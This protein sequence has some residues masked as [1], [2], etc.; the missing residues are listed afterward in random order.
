MPSL[1]MLNTK[2]IIDQQGRPNLN[3]DALGSAWFVKGIQFA[4]DPTAEMNALTNLNVKDSA[5]MNIANQKNIAGINGYDSSASIKLIS[6]S[7]DV[8]QYQANTK[9]TQIAVF[10]EIYYDKGWKAYIDNQEAPILK[11]N[12]LLRSV[13]IPAGAHTVKFEFKPD[14]YYGNILYAQ[15]CQWLNILLILILIGTWIKKYNTTQKEA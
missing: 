6:K 12:Y 14:A 5:V 15:I 8:L 10:S 1:N 3:P 11:A 2:Y 13:V 4:K 7:N 9:N